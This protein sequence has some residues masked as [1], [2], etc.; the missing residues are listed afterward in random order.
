M[1]FRNV[2][3]EQQAFLAASLAHAYVMLCCRS[4]SLLQGLHPS[5]LGQRSLM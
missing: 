1:K 4:R 5:G 2:F 3:F